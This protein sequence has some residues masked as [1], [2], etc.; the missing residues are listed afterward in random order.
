MAAF[1]LMVMAVMHSTMPSKVDP[2]LM[3]V[4]PAVCQKMFLPC[5]PPLK[6]ML[7]APARVSVVPI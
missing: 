7:V 5:A 4:C 3:V 2:V 6:R 1:V